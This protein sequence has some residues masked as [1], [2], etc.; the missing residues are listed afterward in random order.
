MRLRGELAVPVLERTLGEIVRRHEV[1][2]TSFPLLDGR[3]VQVVH[4]LTAFR[5]PVVDLAALPAAVRPAL[6]ERLVEELI[7][8]P[9]VLE[10]G[11][12]IRWRLLRLDPRD[13]LL[14][15]VEHHFVHDGWSLAVLLRE[16][17]T[18][19]EA[20]AR[21]APSPLP[22]PPV[23]YADFAAWQRQWMEGPVMERLLA[24]W[25]Q[26]L[27]GAPPPLELTP[28]RP[29][30]AKG[31]FRGE[32]QLLDVDPGL[33]DALRRFARREGFTLYMT[34]LAGF[35]AL[36]H[37]YTGEEDLLIGTA[38]ANR[39]AREIEGMLGMVVNTLPLRAGLGGRPAWRTLLGRVRDLALATYAHQDMPFERLVQ[40]LRVERRP[41]RNPLFQ[42]LFNFHDA[43]VPEVRIA[44][45]DTQARVRSNHTAKMDMNVIVVP[46][47][48]Q[49]VGQPVADQD[50][51]AL[52]HWEHNTDLFD[53]A[54][55]KR[56]AAHLQI[57]LAGALEAPALPLPELPLLAAAERAQL[58]QGWNDTAAA[59]PAAASLPALVAAWAAHT[60]A[61]PAVVCDSAILT[62]AAL[63]A[64]AGRLAHEL[65]ALGAG[66]GVRVALA[67][68]RSPALVPAIL[69]ILKTGAAYVPLDPGYPQARLAW[70]LADSGA[71]VLA[72]QEH[73]LERLPVT[74]ELPILVLPPASAPLPPPAAP[75]PIPGAAAEPA[76]A[77]D[78]AVPGPDGGDLAYVMYTSG[79]TG[80]PK[81]VAVTHRN[82]IRLVHG[83]AYARFGPEEVF[84]HAAPLSFDAS[85]FELW[86]ALLHGARVVLHPP[87]APTP[88]SLGEVIA[89]HHVTTAWLTAAL[90]HQMVESNLA[91]L[92]PLR[93]LLTGGDAVSPAH[94]RRVLEALPGLTLIDG[95]GPTETTTFAACHV[96]TG[97][98][99]VSG[100]GPGS[101]IGSDAGPGSDPASG[102]GLDHGS[103]SGSGRGL[104]ARAAAVPF[105]RPI[106]NTR[107]HVVDAELRPLPIGVPGELLIGGDGVALGY[108]GRPELTAAR[109]IPDPF[110]AT[111]GEPGGRLYRTGD[112]VRWLPGGALDFLGR[113]DRQVKI[114]GYRVEPGEIEAALAEHPAV[115]AAAV[116]AQPEPGGAAGL[117]L[118]AYVAAADDPSLA[119][120]L[121]R[122]LA[123]RLPPHL[124]PSVWVFLEEL[125]QTAT[126]KVDRRALERDTPRSAAATGREGA[127]IAPRTPEERAVAALWR[128]V[129]GLDQVSAGDDFFLLGGHSLAATR[130]LSR[131]RQEHGADLT[132]ADLFEHTVLADLAAAVA[133]ARGSG[134]GAEAT[135][136]GFGHGA[137]AAAPTAGVNPLAGPGAGIAA[138]KATK[139]L[140]GAAAP[141]AAE[142]AELAQLSDGELDALL[143]ELAKEPGR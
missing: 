142:L 115:R 43:P 85:T 140:P 32:V 70:L 118:A 109:F 7:A 124:V 24:F 40:E 37:R 42:M 61:A 53:P 19:Y 46:R 59:Q 112:R 63:D 135:A 111:D 35:L 88:D 96:L 4:P 123:A 71:R 80:Q 128:Q 2:R 64:W 97:A 103:R 11:P 102:P 120:A 136:Q 36:L 113:L 66:P 100:P 130:V 39:R 13:H 17:K 126:G 18:L 72:A 106:G 86:G 67:A 79:S 84:L 141:S 89:R 122:H 75:R 143:A 119:A 137:D 93:Q 51:R 10:R 16:I 95:Y 132:L 9:F 65:R 73:L 60:P 41:G 20:F 58:L 129:L 101:S 30:P 105:G 125:P 33:Y 12:L 44:D 15:Q 138:L 107:A 28:D 121:R 114:R 22:E 5:L 108:L 127:S 69:G 6:A 49:R 77:D 87:A 90:F 68:E 48:E 78:R 21:R 14:V 74:E 94:A 91:G 92:A 99:S 139:D 47:A 8:I 55:V 52:L 104:Q 110:A 26:Q 56:M 31:S 38:N 76:A 29:R 34:M 98:N 116:V 117:R 45:L 50:R 3:P 133:A 83:S 131:L 57:L 82:V 62:Y 54:T 25:R 1:L 23:Q 81:G 134:H 27:A